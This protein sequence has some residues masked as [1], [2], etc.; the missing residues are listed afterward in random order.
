MRSQHTPHCLQV[1]IRIARGPE[2]S[3]GCQTISPRP[4][5]SADAT[6][7]SP[8]TRA[9]SAIGFIDK[10]IEYTKANASLPEAITAADAPT[11]S[12]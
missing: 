7:G 1:P 12:A 5:S 4:A 11:I 10:M 9:A 6:A 3:N 8:A 2:R